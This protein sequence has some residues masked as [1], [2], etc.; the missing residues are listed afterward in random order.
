MDE[1]MRRNVDGEDEVVP[2]D[3]LSEGFVESDEL[4]NI[5][6]DDFDGDDFDGDGDDL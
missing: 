2:S 5:A 4:G 1:A 3:I 6:E